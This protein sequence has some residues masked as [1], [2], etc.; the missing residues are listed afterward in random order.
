MSLYYNKNDTVSITGAK[1]P[2]RIH[3]SLADPECPTDYYLIC[4]KK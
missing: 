2:G 3:I 4:L 1:I